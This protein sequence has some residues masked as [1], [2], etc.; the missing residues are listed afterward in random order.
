MIISVNK[1]DQGPAAGKPRRAATRQRRARPGG[2]RPL[3][4]PV[5]L[6]GF[7]SNL[8]CAVGRTLHSALV[9]RVNFLYFKRLGSSASGPSR[10]F[11]SSS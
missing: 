2:L 3:T 11:L 4:H 6:A 5:I 7:V 8:G 9:Q 10:R 1:L